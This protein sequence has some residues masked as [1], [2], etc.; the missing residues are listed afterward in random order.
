[1]KKPWVLSYPLSASEDSDQTADAQADLSL[2]WAHI[3]FCWFC[4]EAAQLDS[5]GKLIP[6]EGLG[7]YWYMLEK[8]K[9]ERKFS[10]VN[11]VHAITLPFVLSEKYS[12][13]H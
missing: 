2:R 3:S 7:P 12:P 13:L 9:E 8:G 5:S 10:S 6:G 11:Y 1:M 4:H